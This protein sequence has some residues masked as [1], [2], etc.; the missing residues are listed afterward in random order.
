MWKL[1]APRTNFDA[2]HPTFWIRFLAAQLLIPVLIAVLIGVWWQYTS[3]VAP[4]TPFKQTKGFR[5]SN[6]LGNDECK[7]AQYD[8]VYSYG[9]IQGFF[10][11]CSQYY[12]PV[13]LSGSGLSS[14]PLCCSKGKDTAIMSSAGFWGVGHLDKR[15]KTIEA[16]GGALLS[17]VVRKLTEEGFALEHPPSFLE[18]SVAGAVSTASHGSFPAG[19][20]ISSS[21]LSID[22][23]YANRARETISPKKRKD[24]FEAAKSG[25]GAIAFFE[26]VK[27]SI[28]PQYRLTRYDYSLPFDDVFGSQTALDIMIKSSHWLTLQ[29]SPLC[30]SAIVRSAKPA[31]EGVEISA[32]EDYLTRPLYKHSMRF[33]QPFLKLATYL[34]ESSNT[35]SATSDAAQSTTSTASSS[36]RFH[37]TTTIMNTICSIAKYPITFTDVAS[38]AVAIPRPG[39]IGTWA[40]Y[41]I[42]RAHTAKAAAAVRNALKSAHDAGKINFNGFVSITFVAQEKTTL[43]APNHRYDAAAIEITTFF[44]GMQ[45]E[46]IAIVEEA[47]KPFNPVPHLGSVHGLPGSE[48]KAFYGPERIKSFSDAVYK[49]D[50][51]AYLNNPWKRQNYINAPTAFSNVKL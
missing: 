21:V 27:L 6:Y 23:I 41:Y 18:M 3:P 34:G 42:D 40:E 2:D 10:G 29:F 24:V 22:A 33:I 11:Y 39:N 14:A 37:Y 28:V 35:T 9:Q 7:V 20:S 30:D 5:W 32:T 48:V 47:L 19:H 12:W 17:S 45:P 36:D 16:Q 50:H 38:N 26:N 46:V 1:C 31:I 49:L 43:L 15:A 13:C 8:S 51:H 44:Q 25:L 4:I